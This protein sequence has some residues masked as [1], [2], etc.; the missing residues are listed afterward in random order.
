MLPPKYSNSQRI[1]PNLHQIHSE[2]SPLVEN[3]P[4][5]PTPPNT[6]NNFLITPQVSIISEN[7]VRAIGTTTQ[8]EPKY[9]RV[10]LRNKRNSKQISNG[11]CSNNIQSEEGAYDS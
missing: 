10:D 11:N 2:E 8:E 4:S 6:R 1:N 7:Q 9:A 5:P 3:L